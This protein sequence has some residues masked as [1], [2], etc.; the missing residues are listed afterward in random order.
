M[1]KQAK[2]DELQATRVWV[3]HN[4]PYG[5]SSSTHEL[6]KG[7]IKYLLSCGIKE[8][9]CPTLVAFRHRLK[10]MDFIEPVKHGRK[11]KYRKASIQRQREEYCNCLCAIGKRAA[12]L[13]NR[14]KRRG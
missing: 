7:F 8:D 1:D 2:Q 5:Y 9:D 3:E 6:Y 11:I 14:G 10:N 4:L 12:K 13:L